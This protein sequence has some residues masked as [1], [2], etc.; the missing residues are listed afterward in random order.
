M[1]NYIDG[2]VLPVFSQPGLTQPC[3]LAMDSAFY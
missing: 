1:E 3:A 2:F